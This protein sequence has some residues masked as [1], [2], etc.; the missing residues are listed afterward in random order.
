MK[1]LMIAGESSGDLHGAALARE[2]RAQEP[3]ID[4]LGVGGSKMREEG[5]RLVADVTQ[6]AAVGVVE[7]L[8]NM[9]RFLALYRSLISVLRREKPDA[10]ILIDFPEFNLRFAERVK[11]A[12]IPLIYYIS[13]QVW[14]WRPWRIHRIVELVDRMLVLFDFERELYAG[15]GQ[16]V[17][18]VGHPLLDLMEE[19][20]PGS[21]LRRELDVP[22]DSLLLGLLPGSR[23]KECER[24]MPVMAQ[25]AAGILRERPDARFVVGCAPN[26]DPAWIARWIPPGLPV[27][28]LRGRTYDVMRRS[29]LLLVASGTATLEAAIF[30]TPM[31]MMYKLAYLSYLAGKLLVQID[32]YSLVNIVA[33]RRVIPE[34]IQ[35]AAAPENVTREALSILRNGRLETMRK[36]LGDVRE[37][38]GAPGASAR[39]ATA[40]LDLVRSRGRRMSSIPGSR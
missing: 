27:Q 39:A 26:I 4:L 18:W 23:V 13:P 9:V 10:V 16:D 6:Y 7:P 30:G 29:D 14:A 17:T 38:L 20:A 11:D 32:M 22:P 21:D 33:G 2:L 28:V 35:H 40:A 24:L 25:S 1:V 5:V 36:E 34:L 15:H 37:R 12:R 8:R 3:G 31:I 19:S